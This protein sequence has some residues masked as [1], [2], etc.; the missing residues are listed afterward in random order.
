MLKQIFVLTLI[1]VSALGTIAQGINYG[2]TAGTGG[3]TDVGSDYGISS[4]DG[5]VVNTDVPM[6]LELPKKVVLAAHDGSS[7]TANPIFQG[8]Q[9]ESSTLSLLYNGQ[10]NAGIPDLTDQVLKIGCL[11]YANVDNASLHFRRQAEFVH[12][13]DPNSKIKTMS[14]NGSSGLATLEIFN[15]DTGARYWNYHTIYYNHGFYGFLRNRTD[16]VIGVNMVHG[17]DRT[18]ID[19][20]DRSGKYLSTVTISIVAR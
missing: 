2:A 20:T 12:E 9:A 15:P 4:G 5:A 7:F 14:L 11:V 10:A 6:Q 17:F 1:C 16:N 13:T 8:K 18:T 19:A 3:S